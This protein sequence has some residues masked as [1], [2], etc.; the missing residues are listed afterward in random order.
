M[1]QELIEQAPLSSSAIIV[2]IYLII[3]EMKKLINEDYKNFK[4]I[5]HLPEQNWN[6]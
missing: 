5:M 4:I 3:Y 2:I 1:R 6:Y